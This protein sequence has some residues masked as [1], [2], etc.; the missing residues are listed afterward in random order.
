[1]PIP[2]PEL[3][4]VLVTR[5]RRVGSRIETEIGLFDGGRASVLKAR[6]DAQV[7]DKRRLSRKMYTLGGKPAE[8]D[9]E[10]WVV[11]LAPLNGF[12]AL[13]VLDTSHWYGD[14]K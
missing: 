4:L 3:D 8:G 14:W 10:G 5:V 6:H 12:T 2:E 7:K 13:P 11:T 9:A 1:M